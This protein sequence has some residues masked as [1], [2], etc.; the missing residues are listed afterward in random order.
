MRYHNILLIV[1][2]VFAIFPSV[3][4][5]AVIEE[6]NITDMFIKDFKIRETVV[7]TVPNNQRDIV[8]FGVPKDAFDAEVDGDTVDIV[9][10]KIAVNLDCTYCIVVIEY[11]VPSVLE[12]K[13]DLFGFFKNFEQ[14][15]VH[16]LNYKLLLPEG[17]V[18]ADIIEGMQGPASPPASKIGK[19]KG[20]S[21]MEWNE[22]DPQLPKVYYMRMKKVANPGSNQQIVFILAALV[23]LGIW[24]RRR[25]QKKLTEKTS[26][27]KCPER[28]EES[29]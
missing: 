15:D 13:E 25:R 10:S 8:E 23:V 4:S 20:R 17:Y 18:P 9:D 11:S 29:Q 1:V 12:Q 21:A 22:V 24:L 7:M 2:L 27:N 19:E 14:Y 16:L 3:V 5:A 28:K 6:L 26:E